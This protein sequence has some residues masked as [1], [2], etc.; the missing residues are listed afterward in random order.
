MM[1]HPPSSIF[2]YCM[3]NADLLCQYFMNLKIVFDPDIP[4]QPYGHTPSFVERQAWL[5]N[6]QEASFGWVYPD[7]F[8]LEPDAQ[9]Q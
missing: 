7:T 8:T 4:I 5:E 1:R 2:T 6:I 9:E 3:G